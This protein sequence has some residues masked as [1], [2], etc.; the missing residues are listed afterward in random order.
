MAELRPYPFGALLR[1]VFRELSRE[2]KVLDLPLAKQY[3]G[4]GGRDLSIRFHGHRASTPLGPAAGPHTQMAQNLVLCWLMG[5]R[6]LELKTVQTLDRLEIPRPCIDMRTGS[7]FNVEW[8]QEITLEESAEEY[9]KGRMAIEALRA[10]GELGLEASE[11]DTIF[12]LSVGYDLAGIRGEGVTRF[13]D[14]MR[15]AGEL[16]ERLRAE[17]PPEL[18]ALRDLDFPRRISDTL[19]L[20]TFHG[21]P[22]EEIE[23]IAKYLL[24][25]RGLHTIVKL[26]PTLLGRE[27]LER[28]L[29]EELGY[30]ELVVPEGVVEADA[31]WS[32][33][34]DLLG[35]LE[36][37]ARA[38]GRGFGVK[39]TNTL[40]VENR[41]G[42]LPETE[43]HAYL[44]GAPL[45]LLA[46]TLVRDFRRTFGERLPLS[47]SAGIDRR[48][49]A[50]AVALGLVPVT[51]C[52][53]LL[54]P[55]GY[56]RGHRYLDALCERMD[57][58]GAR[59]IPEWIERASGADEAARLASLERYLE[60]A[61]EEG[62]Y[63][64][65]RNARAPRKIGRALELLDCTACDKCVPVCPNHANFVFRLPVGDHRVPRLRREGDAW[66]VCEV[67]TLSIRSERQ[68]GN[69][70]DFC[71]LCGNCDVFCPEDGGPQLEKPRFFGTVADWRRFAELD[72]FALEPAEGGGR[73]WGRFDGAEYA[74]ELDG[75]RVR[76]EGP[77]FSVRLDPATPA[78][79]LEG[80]AEGDV[81]EL[82]PLL[83]LS[84]IRDAV[85]DAPEVSYPSCLGDRLPF[86]RR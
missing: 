6:V 32:R 79:T 62:R 39:L 43:R 84:W 69:F 82:E 21:C 27:R 13:L 31:S 26:N 77:G 64:R 12:D 25:E 48:N 68:Y 56:A 80:V 42:F 86:P 30:E 8:S 83:L 45:H 19:T 24:R 59:S 10:T 18:A 20:S 71:N 5:A 55:G 75:D 61:L 2:G 15:D 70:A 57:E 9:V 34:V 66:V 1:R 4:A 23:R 67:K 53:D 51:T 81:I 78:E 47:F 35:R 52:T 44:S 50:D 65:E 11:T 73:L 36:R 49:F 33:V 37:I 14:V 3:R 38:E 29:H 76:Y 74:A 58:A 22:P 16:V 60:R 17:I 85:Y 72:G 40:V 7:G 41:A 54:R 46:M 63:A 28:L